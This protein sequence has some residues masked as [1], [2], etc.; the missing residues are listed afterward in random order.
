[1]ATL[2]IL[3]ESAQAGRTRY[4]ARWGN[5][6]VAAETPGKALDALYAMRDQGEGNQTT[7]ILLHHFGPDRFFGEAEQTRLGDLMD[8]FHDSLRSAESLSAAEQAELES[9]VEAELRASAHRA[10]TL[11]EESGR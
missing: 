10:T 11:A 4:R 8:E 6:Q 7:V 2:E 9:L 5:R 3:Q 1:M